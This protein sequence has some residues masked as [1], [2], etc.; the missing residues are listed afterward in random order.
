MK[1]IHYKKNTR[2]FFE[3]WYLKHDNGKDTVAFIP[4]INFD[5]NGKADAFI[6]IITGDNSYMVNYDFKDVFILKKKFDI[7]IGG[8][9]FSEEGIDINITAHGFICFGK[10]NYGKFTELNYNMMGPFCIIPNLECNHGILSLAHTL[11]GKLNL[12]GKEINFD[13]GYGYIEK[14]WGRSFPKAYTWLHFKEKES[15]N[16]VMLSIANI[17]FM[18]KSFK[19]HIAVVY[20]NGIQYRFATYNFS[21]IKQN[22][23]NGIIL[24]K[25]KYLLKVFILDST[26]Q[27]LKAP[28]AGEMTRIIF[29]RAACNMDIEFYKGKRCVFKKSGRASYEKVIG[30]TE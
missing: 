24:K 15:F 18:G 28:K 4:G 22:S 14:D 16:S 10:I 27:P 3:G 5:K 20:E 12:N 7:K 30:Q 21:R 11:S 23:D 17:P 1:N 19:G 13:N 2:S 6:Q 26:G 9:S 25:G 29:E 8:N